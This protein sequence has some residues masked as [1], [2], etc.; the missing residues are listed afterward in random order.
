MIG[1]ENRWFEKWRGHKIW[2]NCKACIKC[3]IFCTAFAD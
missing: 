1:T 2:L 3:V